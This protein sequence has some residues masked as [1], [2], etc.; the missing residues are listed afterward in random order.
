[1][2]SVV[3][4]VD[5]GGTTTSAGAVTERG[6][7]LIHA[8]APTHGGGPATAGR[9]IVTLIESVL[10]RA[11][12]RGLRPAGIGVGLPGI[13]DP[14][15]GVIGEEAPHVADLQ[16]QRLGQ[17][18]ADRF[19][20]PAFI[21]NDVNVLA[22]G[23]YVFG[24]DSGVRSLVVLAAGTGFGS[25]IILDGH[26]VRGVHGFGGEFGHAPVKFDGRACWCGGRGCLAVYASGRG[27]AEAAQ[28]Q[29][30]PD[31]SSELLRLAGGDPRAVTAALVFQAAASGDP[32]AAGIVEEACRA[33]GAAIAVIV[34][35]LNPEVVVITGGV[36][37]AYAPLEKRVL[38]AAAEHAFARALVATRVSIVPADKRYTMRGA[39]ALVLHETRRG[40]GPQGGQ[41]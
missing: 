13:V 9:T 39:A 29:A 28:E 10:D 5:V 26:L 15:S 37:A 4:G 2:T 7:V 1:M 34:N 16:G 12:R 23:E 24:Q 22:L 27:I 33:L 17:R 3:V 11:A 8:H 32:V 21:D 30:G 18:L 36:A 35:G 41:R 19:G 14:S 20:L 31:A 40:Q 25:G 6:E 38:A